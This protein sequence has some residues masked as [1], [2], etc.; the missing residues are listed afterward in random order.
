PFAKPNEQEIR[1]YPLLDLL[2]ANHELRLD[3][4][5]EFLSA[6]HLP[7]YQLPL[8]KRYI[9]Q[10]KTKT[11]QKKLARIL[12]G[13]HFNESNLKL[14]LISL[15]LDFHSVADKNSCMAK[16]LALA[17]DDK[18]FSKVV[19][20][21][22]ELE[23]DQEILRWFNFLLDTNYQDLN[24]ENIIEL[25]RKVKYNVLTAYIDK[26]VKADN[27]NKLKL[28]R[29]ADINRLQSFFQDWENHPGLKEQIE[30]VFNQLAA[31]IKTNNLMAW[32][33]SEYEFGYYS[34]DMLTGMISELY[35]TALENPV[36][37]KDECIKWLRN[38][39]LSDDQ[40][41]QVKFI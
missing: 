1:K 24:R 27:Y 36:K 26:P 40:K 5:S 35:K 32:Y 9:K 25:A 6:Y 11:N 17:T 31:D 14:G 30:L 8:V 12:D 29:S 7:E 37:T 23:L 13:S 2:K 34:E 10:L 15:T 18:A 4:A 20:S 28:Q 3:D 39:T 33:G 19:K 16:C 22:F 41:E 21:L 38:S